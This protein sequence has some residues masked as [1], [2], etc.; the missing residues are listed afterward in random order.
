M[1]PPIV[2]LNPRHCTTTQRHSN[3]LKALRRARVATEHAQVA[4]S[5]AHVAAC[6]AAQYEVCKH[7]MQFRNR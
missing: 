7:A 3:C 6:I 4:E 2:V 1:S 5:E